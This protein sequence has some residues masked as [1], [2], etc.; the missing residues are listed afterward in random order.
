MRSARN[1]SG[2]VWVSCPFA[3][4]D[5]LIQAVLFP[6][7]TPR[8]NSAAEGLKVPADPLPDQPGIARVL[9]NPVPVAKSKAE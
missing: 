2:K 6:S 5:A 3:K 7:V 9:L 4:K 8:G 1:L